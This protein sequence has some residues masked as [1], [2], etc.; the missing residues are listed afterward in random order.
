[1]N[2]DSYIVRIYRRETD[3][4]GQRACD[5]VRLVGRVEPVDGRPAR[6]F[7]DLHELWAALCESPKD[8]PLETYLDKRRY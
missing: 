4:D 8:S 7:H 2:G 1:M 5:R 3:A 6:A